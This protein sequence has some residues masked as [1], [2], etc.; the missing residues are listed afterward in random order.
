MGGFDYGPGAIRC[1][2]PGQMDDTVPDRILN[3]LL[4]AGNRSGPT[5]R[6]TPPPPPPP[7]PQRV[8][9]GCMAAALGRNFLGNGDRMFWTAA[10]HATAYA[11]IKR[12][13]PAVLPGPGWAYVGLAVAWDG[14]QITKSY[15]DCKYNGGPS[16]R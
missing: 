12:L 11:A 8:T 5:M 14:V 2:G 9:T 15:V 10:V 6:A 7:S 1:L 13:A 4:E 16:P 3:R